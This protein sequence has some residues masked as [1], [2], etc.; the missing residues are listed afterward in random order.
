MLPD[1]A[2]ARR[3]AP[4]PKA[5]TEEGDQEEVKTAARK[6]AFL[7][8]HQQVEIATRTGKLKV[9]AGIAPLVF[10]LN[11]LPEVSTYSSCECSSYNE[12]ATV[13]F[14]WAR[15][16]KRL[17]MVPLFDALARR[18]LKTPNSHAMLKMYWAVPQDFPALELECAPDRPEDITASVLKL[19]LSRRP[20]QKA[21]ILKRLKAN[22]LRRGVKSRAK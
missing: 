13:S 3:E 17:D 21:A 14:E 5:R 22:F 8:G 12:L 2:D 16:Y 20:T 6:P 19:C 7:P 15:G 9:D 18:I 1:E 10:A 11:E 4:A